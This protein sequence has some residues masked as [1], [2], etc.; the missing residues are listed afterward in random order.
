MCHVM[1][2]PV[3]AIGEQNNKD[4]DQPAHPQSD[5]CLCYSLSI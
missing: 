3:F 4:T 1:R 2:K 5:Q